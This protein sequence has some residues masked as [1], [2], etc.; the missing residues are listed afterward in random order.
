MNGRHEDLLLLAKMDNGKFR[1]SAV[2]LPD[3]MDHACFRFVA[4][5]NRPDKLLRSPPPVGD[6]DSAL[7]GKVA[8]VT[9]ATSGIG[10]AIAQRFIDEGP[11]TF[12][13]G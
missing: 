7:S 6:G 3:K 11:Y 2:R 8:V 12:R 5:F 9:G 10:L 4:S 13:A 1:R